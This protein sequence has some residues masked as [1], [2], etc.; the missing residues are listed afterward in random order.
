MVILFLFSNPFFVT[1]LHLVIKLV[2]HSRLAVDFLLHVGKFIEE[3]LISFYNSVEDLERNHFLFPIKTFIKKKN[4]KQKRGIR[5][6]L[7]WHSSMNI[8][9]YY[10]TDDVFEYFDN[11]LKKQDDEPQ[12]TRIG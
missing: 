2:Y 1:F 9:I 10:F 12:F 8:I 5:K 11:W 6:V 3:K 7:K 4:K